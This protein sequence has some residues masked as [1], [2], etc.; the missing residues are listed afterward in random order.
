MSAAEMFLKVW[1]RKLKYNKKKY[2]VLFLFML[3]PLILLIGTATNFYI[4]YTKG[5]YEFHDR[6][7]GA[8]IRVL[9]YSNET[10]FSY[11]NKTLTERLQGTP[12]KG[13]VSYTHFYID[14]ECQRNLTVSYKNEIKKTFF[15]QTPNF[16]GYNFSNSKIKYFFLNKS[17]NL[18]SGRLPRIE[19]ETIMPLRLRY[20][21]NLTLNS[22]LNFSLKKNRTFTFKV[23][24]FFENIGHP[25]YYKHYLKG[26]FIF[27]V[28]DH[29]MEQKIGDFE[30]IIYQ[31]Y[32]DYRQMDIF[33]QN[34]LIADISD[35]EFKVKRIF[36]DRDSPSVDVFSSKSQFYRGSW[37]YDQFQLETLSHLIQ[38]LFPIFI[39]IGI[40]NLNLSNYLSKMETKSWKKIK[41]YK[42]PTYL[43]RQF[44]FELM[45]ENI[46][47]FAFALPLGIGLYCFVDPSCMQSPIPYVIPIYIWITIIIFDFIFYL[48]LLVTTLPKTLI[49]L[50]IETNSRFK[51]FT[52]FKSKRKLLIAVIIFIFLFPIFSSVFHFILDF[53]NS[54]LL[55]AI[56]YITEDISK[57]IKTFHIFFLLVLLILLG[58]GLIIKGI[59][60]ISSRLLKGFK[61]VLVKKL[62]LLKGF[63][64]FNKKIIITSIL[65][66]M[67][68]IGFINYY[69]TLRYNR[70]QNDELKISVNIGSDFK[71]HER[72]KGGEYFSINYS[73]YFKDEKYSIAYSI[74]GKLE[75]HSFPYPEYYTMVSINPDNYYTCLNDQSKNLLNPSFLSLIE[76]LSSNEIL[77]PSYFQIKHDLKIGDSIKF[78]PQN[79]SLY[80]NS[81]EVK[82][83]DSYAKVLTIRGFFNHFPGIYEDDRLFWTLPD[84]PDLSS[85]EDNR[86]L[87]V[88]NSLFNLSFEF[89]DLETQK[90]VLIKSTN[91]TESIIRNFIHGVS[92]PHYDPI[93]ISLKEELFILHKDTKYLSESL[94]SIYTFFIIVLMAMNS[95]CIIRFVNENDENWINFQLWGVKSREVR[96]VMF[97]SII[98]LFIT[99]FLL[100]FLGVINGLFIHFIESMR[101]LDQNYSYPISL[102]LSPSLLRFNLIYLIGSI[103]IIL[104]YSFKFT[105]IT[106]SYTKIKRYYIE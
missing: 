32:L 17:I 61:G 63:Y 41:M 30:R 16:N 67:L 98:S 19:N 77:L 8:D 49:N 83:V 6:Y 39:L 2:L 101:E 66:I 24:G 62:N 81:R 95:L 13:S 91:K 11:F 84:S 76:N 96:I 82:F 31:I 85:G 10:K 90:I 48:I 105:N 35:V 93:V 38:L 100:G 26:D 86:A 47:C 51:R 106:I 25:R 12:Y 72:F 65:F 78:L 55:Y 3:L 64:S 50:S 4:T 104:L 34:S 46:I 54:P 80:K 74:S 52:F 57:I 29:F 36:K 53:Y 45:M 79:I 73:A 68:G 71:I 60:L 7:I 89:P 69:Q 42:S 14:A 103:L 21:Y 43:K 22:E 28:N 27:F 33:N 88:T 9:K 18:T 70:I 40:F 1:I 20:Y 59:T 75:D 15:N 23:V 94:L 5:F 56:P 37:E 99:A 44:S 87:M 58:S 92:I 97:G 102:S